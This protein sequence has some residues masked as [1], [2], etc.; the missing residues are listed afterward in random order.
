MKNIAIFCMIMVTFVSFGCSR[1]PKISDIF[2]TQLMKF[3][4]EGAKT[5]AH[6]SQGVSYLELRGQV[7]SARGAYDLLSATWPADLEVD[8]RE[9][10]KKSL[11]AWNLTLDLWALKIGEK[12]NPTEP[13]VNG[14]AKFSAYSGGLLITKTYGYNHIIRRYRGKKYIPIDENI[15]AL[16]TMAG[17]SFNSGRDKILQALQ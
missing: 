12:D 1:K 3:L 2:K 15:R 8:C 7:A 10:F 13:N 9:D 17:L 11:E 6:V 4:E 14:Y 16:L 5:N